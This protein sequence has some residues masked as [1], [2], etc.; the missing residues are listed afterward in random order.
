MSQKLKIDETQNLDLTGNE[1][2]CAD[3][4]YLNLAK[5]ILA[6]TTNI[7]GDRT[8]TG[9]FSIFGEMI[10][11][12]LKKGFPLLT[13][14]KMHYKGIFHEL[15]WFLKGDTNIKYLLENKVN[16]WTDNA[17]DFYLKKCKLW[18]TPLSKE[19]FIDAVKKT[20]TKSSI[21]YYTYGDLGDVYGKQWRDWGGID[22]ISELIFNLKTN[23][24]SRR[25]IVSAWNVGKLE[26]MA[27]PPCHM[28]FQLYSKELSFE[29]R[30]TLA[31]KMSDNGYKTFEDV[32]ILQED[33]VKNT[34][35]AMD[36]NL[37]PKRKL[38]L[39]WT[40]RSC[41]YFLGAP[42]NINSYALLLHM[43]AQ[44][45]N[46]TVDILIGSLGDVHIYSNHIDAINKQLSNTDNLYPL[47]TIKLNTEIKNIFDFKYEDIEIIDYKSNK[48]IKAKMAV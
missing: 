44:V 15:L 10:K 24:D 7:K 12:D 31:N 25:L 46:H 30:Y 42:Y 13:S 36:N 34:S 11:F 32:Y 9:T 8:G 5:K 26:N 17:Y 43:I 47:P 14:K 19:H 48:S 23:P 33:F 27:L 16:I 40:Q 38:S 41:D 18:E 39:M 28:F 22:Q 37:I 2:N 1:I 20:S 6:E 4:T 29:E 3:I 21:P 45:T 35:L